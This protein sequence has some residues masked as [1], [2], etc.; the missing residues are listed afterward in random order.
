M[1]ARRLAN[2][3]QITDFTES[4]KWCDNF[5][6][7]AKLSIRATTSIGQS[8]F[9]NYKQLRSIFREYVAQ[10]TISIFTDSIG[11]MDEVPV[12]FDFTSSVHS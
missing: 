1:H 6:K 11:N 5:M 8:L 12:A 9:K 3:F 10:Q 7:R 4:D 2:Q